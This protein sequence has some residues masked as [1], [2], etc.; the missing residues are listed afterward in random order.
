LTCRDPWDRALTLLHEASAVQIIDQ[1][2]V[3]RVSSVAEEK[4]PCMSNEFLTLRR[5][6]LV[7]SGWI[8][9]KKPCMRSIS[10]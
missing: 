1:M 5:H 6:Q 2:I 7:Q 3:R 10:S 9:K 8:A 4:M